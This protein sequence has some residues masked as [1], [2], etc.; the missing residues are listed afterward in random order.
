MGNRQSK[1][2]MLFAAWTVAVIVLGGVFTSY[3][4]PLRTPSDQILSIAP[5]PAAPGWRA[6]HFLS[7]SC[8]C[9]QRVMRHI[10]SRPQFDG[11]TEQLVLV[12]DHEA[13][14]P[15]S[16]DLIQQL[17][18]RGFASRRVEVRDIPEGVGLRGVPL[19][20]VASP[21]GHIA[22]IGGY[23][24]HSDQDANI[25]QKVRSGA[26]AS[27]LPIVGCAVGRSLRSRVDPFHLKYTN[28]KEN[29][30]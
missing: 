11:F 2:R 22:Y 16:D 24:N 27:A 20:V 12:D 3:H 28:E 29:E 4:Q 25:M 8:G 6:V 10:L 5:K 30:N 18:A 23:G 17:R 21:E 9:S 19:L 14:L 13:P 7:A 15:D 1:I 26:V